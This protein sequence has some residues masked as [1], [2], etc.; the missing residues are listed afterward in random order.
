MVT[1]NPKTFIQEY[2]EALSGKPK[3][4]ELINKYI[5]DEHL[6]GHIMAYEESFPCYELIAEDMIC[7]DNKVA[8]RA[9]VKAEHKGKLMGYEPTGKAIDIPLSVIYW[10][11]DDKIAKGWIFVDQMELMNQLG[12]ISIN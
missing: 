10:I 3:T 6:A 2:F 11:E 7:E 1:V 9:R 12:L 5:S 4:M 8:V